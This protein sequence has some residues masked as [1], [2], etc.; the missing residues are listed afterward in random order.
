MRDLGFPVNVIRH[1]S[2]GI[3][4][5]FCFQLIFLL[6]LSYGYCILLTL[7]DRSQE[8]GIAK[9]FTKRNDSGH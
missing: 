7:E 1:A 9:G 5:V 2:S 3:L 8:E 6:T 4:L